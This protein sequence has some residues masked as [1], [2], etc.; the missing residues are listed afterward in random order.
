MI[1]D[2][3]AA[4]ETGKREAIEREDFDE[5][6]KM[7]EACDEVK[8]LGHQIMNLEQQLKKAIQ[9]E[10]FDTC[11]VIKYELERLRSQAL[12]S[13]RRQ[14]TPITHQKEDPEMMPNHPPENMSVHFKLDEEQSDQGYHDEERPPMSQKLD[15]YSTYPDDRP[16]KP[17]A[18]FQEKMIEEKESQWE[19][20]K[21]EYILNRDEMELGGRGKDLVDYS[22]VID[23]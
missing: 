15:D 2:K 22:A 23:D 6:K 14:L 5:A 4:L 7:K 1:K 8:V 20:E 13:P 9:G 18:E 12:G 16:I 19:Q 11:K 21:Q 10:D 3:L 17:A